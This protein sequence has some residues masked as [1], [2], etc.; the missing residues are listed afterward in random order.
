[1]DNNDSAAVRFETSYGAFVLSLH[2]SRA[3]ETSLAFL[4]YVE[5]GRFRGAQLFRAVTPE[6]DH[7]APPISILQARL[8]LDSDPDC[9]RHEPTSQTGIHH[10]KGTVSLARAAVG[11]AKPG[12]FF[13]CLSDLPCLDQGGERQPDGFG[14]AAFGQIEAGLE[15]IEKLQAGRTVQSSGDPYLRGQILIDPPTILKASRV[16]GR[17]R[18]AS[19]ICH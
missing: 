12:D 19:L 17:T 4:S 8:P 1:M 13:I 2:L 11:T 5:Q 7:G 14:F 10:R 16:G 9:V 6:N 18:Q 15:L 3:P